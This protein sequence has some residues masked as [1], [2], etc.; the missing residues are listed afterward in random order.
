MRYID[1]AMQ[2]RPRIIFERNDLWHFGSPRL[3]IHGRR[4]RRVHVGHYVTPLNIQCRIREQKH[5]LSVLH[6]LRRGRLAGTLSKI[7]GYPVRLVLFLFSA[8]VCVYAYSCFLILTIDSSNVHFIVAR[9]HYRQLQCLQSHYMITPTTIII[10]RAYCQSQTGRCASENA[11]TLALNKWV[12]LMTVFG[13][14]RSDK[15]SVEPAESVRCYFGLSSIRSLT[16][17]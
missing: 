2:S 1:R 11:V 12:S 13:V 7:V 17:P 4:K 15:R 9:R 8:V 10:T 5:R 3:Y 6:K 14:K 16:E